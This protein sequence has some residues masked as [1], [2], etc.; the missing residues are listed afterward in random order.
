LEIGRIRAKI[1]KDWSAI[2]SID[3]FGAQFG[4]KVLDSCPHYAYGFFSGKF[5]PNIMYYI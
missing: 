3:H 5:D 1:K 2:L 4:T